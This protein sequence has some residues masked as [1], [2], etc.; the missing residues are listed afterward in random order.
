M[1]GHGSAGSEGVTADVGLFV[2][3]EFVETM[4]IGALFE[5]VV[6]VVSRDGLPCHMSGIGVFV[7]VNS[8]VVASSGHDVMDA[9]GKRF[10][11]AVHR[12]GALLVE[13][14][15]FHSVLL[16]GVADGCID[17]FVKFVQRGGVGDGVALSVVEGDMAN[18][19]GFSVLLLVLWF[20]AL[21]NAKQKIES[22][23]DEVSS[24]QLLAQRGGSCLGV[25][26]LV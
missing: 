5:R 19:E 26:C 8:F 13:C 16:V 10:D 4:A 2:V 14:L 24:C 22:D 17:S 18:P 6:D 15:A 21:S 25:E 23:V 1:E 7:D 12:F 11:G 20:G 9:T 3:A